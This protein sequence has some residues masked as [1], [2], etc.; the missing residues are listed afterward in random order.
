MSYYVLVRGPLGVGKTTVSQKLALEL[1]AQYIS[2]DRVLDEHDLWYDG[3]LSEFL[4][5][6]VIVARQATTRLKQRTPVV[7]DGNFYW[8][9]QIKDL[10]R[11]LPY[12]HFVFTLKAPLNVCIE[13]DARRAEPHGVRAARE[14]YTKS[15]RVVCGVEVDATQPLERIVQE[16]VRSVSAGHPEREK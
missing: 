7:L 2:I 16:M 11:R 4:R 5:V 15:T 13:R 14:V 8:K 6:N 9:T 12:P 3:R 1:R 10:E